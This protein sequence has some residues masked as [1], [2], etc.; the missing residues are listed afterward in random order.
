MTGHKT[1]LNLLGVGWIFFGVVF[2]LSPAINAYADYGV[3]G[4]L[5][6]LIAYGSLTFLPGCVLLIAANL[7]KG[8]TRRIVLGV[9]T[10]G[11]MVLVWTWIALFILAPA[12]GWTS[13][14]EISAIVAG[15]VQASGSN[16]RCS[17]VLTNYGDA[18]TSTTKV[19]SLTFGGSTHTATFTMTSGSLSPSSSESGTCTN[20]DD[21]V[22][23][24]GSQVTGSIFLANGGNAIFSGVAS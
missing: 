11:L 16:E 5:L 17:V 20:S 13:G 15:C 18:G 10:I 9:A 24:V 23:P 3:G 19:C 22:A 12:P 14:P 7:V 21:A 2:C 4:F 8:R 1:L 6:V